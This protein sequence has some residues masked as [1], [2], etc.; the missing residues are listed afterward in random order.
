MF[1]KAATSCRCTVA[2]GTGGRGR[3]GREDMFEEAATF[4]RWRC[5]WARGQGRR[6]GGGKRK[7]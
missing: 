6:R 3:W 7:Q 4:C 1:E 5:I 2:E